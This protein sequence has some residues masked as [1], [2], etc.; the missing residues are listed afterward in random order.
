[1]GARARGFVDL[2]AQMG[3]SYWQ[4]LPI[5]HYTAGGA[6]YSSLSL[7][8]IHPNFIDLNEFVENGV[9]SDA[10][11]S[12][13]YMQPAQKP[14]DP[15][16]N[17]KKR[18]ILLRKIYSRVG[19]RES[20]NVKAFAEKNAHWLDAYALFVVLKNYFGDLAW[21]EWPVV[22]LRLHKNDAIDQA[23]IEYGGEVAFWKFIQYVA[24][25]QWAEL[26]EYANSN[27]ISII[28]DIPIYAAFDSADVW[29]G[30]HLFQLN[31]KHIPK[32]VGGVPPDY[33]NK[34]GQ[35]WGN[36]LY[37]W[38]EMKKNGYQW[39]MGRIENALSLY[40]TVRIDHFRGL[41]AYW[42]VPFVN[43]T[44][45]RGE[46]VKGPG[47]DLIKRI[48]AGYPD[49][50]LIMEDLGSIDRNVKRFFNSSGLAGMRVM[51]F[52]FGKG[53]DPAHLAKNY[54]QECVAYTGTH[55]NNTILGWYGETSAET[56][57]A[58]YKELGLPCA[59]GGKPADGK[60]ICRAW[61]ESLLKSEAGLV[62]VPIQDLLYEG[63]GSR[64]NFPGTVSPQNW[65][66]RVEEDKLK[67]VLDVGWMAALNKKFNR[68]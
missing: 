11:L 5:T 27:G 54:P 26:R 34:N 37:D 1:M 55:D 6:P 23:F 40:D 47:M 67:S 45:K 3:C 32:Q 20:A 42:A 7:F 65:S 36:P 22:G 4:I 13:A 61:I 58:S 66:Y 53:G 30:N 31:T 29:A 19:E 62:V 16:I 50:Q 24:Y 56:A 33:F 43:K 15:A 25:K 10:E 8:A 60:D 68:R 41:Y 51:Q 52:G 57:E 49:T 35:L 44:A 18:L 38:R 59:D 9:I 39:W 46:W 28:G 12:D 14:A 21:N 64:M 17:E 48:K 63:A 2:L